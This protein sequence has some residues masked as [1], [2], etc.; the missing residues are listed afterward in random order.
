M[1][2]LGEEEEDDHSRNSIF[3]KDIYEDS[4]SNQN[5]LLS[6]CLVIEWL[7]KGMIEWL[8]IVQVMV[9]VEE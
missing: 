9:V 8:A 5:D 4:Y 1:E 6:H 3:S 7:T 2:S